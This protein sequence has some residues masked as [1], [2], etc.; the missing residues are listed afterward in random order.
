MLKIFRRNLVV[1]VISFVFA[2]LFWLFVMNQGTTAQLIP[3]QTYTIPL[4]TTGLPKNMVVMTEL[5]SVLV[6]LQGINPSANI[7]N[8]YAQVDL[9]EGKAGE[10]SYEIKVNTPVGTKAVDVQPSA[11]LLQLDNV[12]EKTVPVEAIVS[13]VP[14]DGYE[15]GT[16][17]VKPSAVN[18]RGPSSSLSKLT[19]VTVEVSAKGVNE[20]IQISLPVSF[21]DKEGKPIFGSNSNY[22]ILSAF[23]STVDVIVPVVAKGLSS[24][25]VPLKITSSGTPA[26]GKILRSLVPSPL[27][28]QVLGTDQAL[29]GFDALNLGPVDI[30]KLSEDKVFQ[31]PIERVALP[32][33]VSFNSGTTLSVVA[34]I[35][36]GIIQ[37]DISGVEVQIRDLGTGLEIVLEGLPESL[38]DVTAAQIQ[39]WVDATGQV[40]GTYADAKVYWQLPPG[41]T[42]PITPQVKYS[43]KDKLVK[44]AE[45]VSYTHLTL[46]TKRIV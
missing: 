45:S 13:G 20:T 44:G 1:K 15:L 43:L 29:K 7:N 41:L 12:L 2:I 37:K 34:Q 25:M 16:T 24:K 4:V 39:L 17:F 23:P 35:G 5:P 38:K 26:Q 42:M 6:R 14:A 40:A 18:V 31:I 21:R 11:I 3:E 9:S 30:D 22:D 46:P 27:R 8:I 32:K 28:V 19:K 36:Q 10:Q 33:G